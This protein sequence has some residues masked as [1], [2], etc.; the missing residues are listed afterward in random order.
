MTDIVAYV[1]LVRELHER[2]AK[3]KQPVNGVFE[4]TSLCN[5][6]CGM[7]YVRRPGG[8]KAPGMR[9]E[10]SSS[11]WLEIAG[12]ARE[13]GLIFLLLTGGEVFLRNDFFEI[14]D[15][16]TRMGFMITLFTNGAL[17][18]D[19]IADRLARC[20][21]S[22][23]EISL[24]GATAATCEKIT[25]VPGSF[26]AC[27]T[28]IENLLARRIPLVLKSTLSRFNV[29][30][31]EAMRQMA[32]GWGVPFYASWLLSRR[33]DKQGS[34][35]EDYRLS[36]EECVEL[37]ATDRA[38]ANE[39]R[40][41]ALS[42]KAPDSDTNFYCKAGRAAFIVNPYGDLNVCS[43]LPEPAARPLEIGFHN[44]W[45][46]VVKYVDSAPAPSPECI[47]CR[48]RVFCGRCPAWS[49]M[50]GGTLSGPVPYWCDIARARNK[51]YGR[52]AHPSPI[53]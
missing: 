13:D 53:E 39:L 49:L 40:E 12:Q 11:Q 31:L 1:P 35:V 5:L 22:R 14:Y 28:G 46:E 50:E 51:R 44:A 3:L 27:R 10:L 41:A 30:E 7:C 9:K 29:A 32:H 47:G 4:L 18:T 25:G 24:Y 38:S 15:P 19:S 45:M 26:A 43:L 23:V 37:E 48:D 16:L 36:A 33:P 34:E 8:G 20:P 2:A 17:I 52:P 42:E 21:P 6:R